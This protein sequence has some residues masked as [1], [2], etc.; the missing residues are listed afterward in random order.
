M[1]RRWIRV[2]NV[3]RNSLEGL[4]GQASYLFLRDVVVATCEEGN[5]IIGL[6]ASLQLGRLYAFAMKAS[7]VAKDL[8]DYA[9]ARLE[10]GLVEKRGQITFY[11]GSL[12][13]LTVRGSYKGLG[14]IAY[15]SVGPERAEGLSARAKELLDRVVVEL[16]AFE[17]KGLSPKGS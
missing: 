8:G 17:T 16:R 5:H 2:V 1:V 14:V 10:G 13:A 3:V 4:C 12:T 7:G 15:A 9:C 6:C 11:R